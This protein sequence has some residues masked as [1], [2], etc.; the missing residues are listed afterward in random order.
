MVPHVRQV[1]AIGRPTHGTKSCLQ[2]VACAAER[3]TSPCAYIVEQVLL[4]AAP[5]LLITEM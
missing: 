4:R 1:A 5:A 3:Q 2:A